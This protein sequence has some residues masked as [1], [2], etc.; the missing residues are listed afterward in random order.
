MGVGTVEP[1][2]RLR[3]L[4]C[5]GCRE[6]RGQGSDWLVGATWQ[7]IDLPRFAGCISVALCFELLEPTTQFRQ[8]TDA[9]LSA[10]GY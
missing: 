3:S 1:T 8:W 4:H 7:I 9:V 2:A 10:V 5:L 6:G